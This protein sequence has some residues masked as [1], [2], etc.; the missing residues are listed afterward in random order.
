VGSAVGFGLGSD[1]GFAVGSGV[2][3]AV[4]SGVGGAEGFSVGA[5]SVGDMDGSNCCALNAG[6]R[7]DDMLLRVSSLYSSSLRDIG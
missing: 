7:R 4:G 5:A 2:G 3:D 6:N 1:D